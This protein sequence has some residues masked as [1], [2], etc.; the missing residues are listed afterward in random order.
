MPAYLRAAAGGPEWDGPRNTL[1]RIIVLDQF[2]RTAYRATA[3]A[4]ARD[5]MAA[6][7]S[8]AAIDAGSDEQFTP[9]ERL[10]FYL[11]LMH[12]ERMEYQRLCLAK[13]TSTPGLEDC[14]A[15]ANSHLVVVEQFG[16]FPHRNAA[17]GRTSTPEELAWL[18]SDKL[19]GWAR[20]QAPP[21][22]G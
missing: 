4:F 6:D 15:F 19:P 8:A 5:E 7:I 11:P 16:R 13:V 22:Q 20:S 17:M 3:Q 1:A 14:I 9:Y 12:S 21:P 18:A 10:F 2:S